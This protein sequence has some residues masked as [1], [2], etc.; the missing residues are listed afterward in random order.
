[1]VSGAR[2]R[3]S[4]RLLLLLLLPE[5]LL[6]HP[7]TTHAAATATKWLAEVPLSPPRL[8]MLLM[9]RYRV[10]GAGLSLSLLRVTVVGRRPGH[11]QWPAHVPP[12]PHL[13]R[14]RATKLSGCRRR[15]ELFHDFCVPVPVF[16]V[17]WAT[18]GRVVKYFFMDAASIHT[19]PTKHTNIRILL[20]FARYPL[21][22]AHRFSTT[23]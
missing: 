12:R 19:Q 13:R 2:W 1:M 6:L 21:I 22:L 23:S 5:G 9:R 4:I 7:P 17:R 8:L 18:G 14:A 16:Q 15:A 3:M 11:R 10:L 20:I